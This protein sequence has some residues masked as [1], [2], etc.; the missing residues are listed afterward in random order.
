MILFSESHTMDFPENRNP[1]GLLLLGG[2]LLARGDLALGL[3]LALAALA[4]HAE[5]RLLLLFLLALP[6]AFVFQLDA[7]SP[8]DCSQ[9]TTNA[10]RHPKR[11]LHRAR[12]APCMHTQH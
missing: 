4:A 9:N 5:A 6:T 11:L 3:V 12:E 2:I 1:P 10:R 7:F 8:V